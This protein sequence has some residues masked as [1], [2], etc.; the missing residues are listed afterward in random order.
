MDKFIALVRRFEGLR[1]KSYLCPAGVWTIGYGSTG[2][3]IKKGVTWTLKQ[4]E[5]RMRADC[6]KFYTA[7]LKLAPNLSLSPIKAQAIADFCYNLGTTKFKSSTLRKRILSNEWDDVPYQLSRWVN[8][9]GRK[10]KGLVKRRD[11]EIAL[12]NMNNA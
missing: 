2:P 8:G 3:G 7:T 6:R 9:G 11:A 10:L 12:W 4:S 5:A 1:L